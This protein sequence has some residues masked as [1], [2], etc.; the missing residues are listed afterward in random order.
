[1]I[2]SPCIGQFQS[3]DFSCHGNTLFLTRTESSASPS[4]TLLEMTLTAG[5]CQQK[6]GT[7]HRVLGEL[8]ILLG[9]GSRIFNRG[10]VVL[11]GRN[12]A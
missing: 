1:M 12:V 9:G 11:H 6:D 5:S 4:C 3:H 7:L 8:N 2:W 10:L